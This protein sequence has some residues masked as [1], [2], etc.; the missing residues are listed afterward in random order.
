MCPK[1]NDEWAKFSQ[2]HLIKL[3]SQEEDKYI[4]FHFNNLFPGL[5]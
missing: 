1:D 5:L 2:K 3:L 4:L